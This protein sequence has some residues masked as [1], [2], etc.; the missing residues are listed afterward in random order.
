MRG[1]LGLNLITLKGAPGDGSLEER[2]QAAAKAGFEGVGLWM[3]DL[4]WWEKEKGNLKRL[5][6]LIDSLGLSVAEICAVTVCDDE[7]KVASRLKEFDQAATVGAHCMICIY[8][9]REARVKTAR[10]QWAEFLD[11]LADF[12][13]R[14]AFEFIGSTS[15]YN[16]LDTALDVV[17]GGPPTGGIVVDTYHFWRGHSNINTL[18][19]LTP[20][21]LVLVHLNDVK[22]VDREK[23]TDR[24]RT[25][26]GE[27]IM[28]L[29]H[30]LTSIASTGYEGMYDVEIFGECQEQDRE[31]V[32]KTSADTARK[33]LMKA[34][35]R[36]G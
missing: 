28:P 1:Q 24:D 35:T 8:N 26:P 30:I 13:V 23:A 6:R 25:Y 19:H 33:A 32:A 22:R 29:T 14:A 12:G 3:K 17:T 20:N 15:A 16:T 36:Q 2:L 11:P 10:E 7:K 5:R 4:E 21:Q 9:N 18:S 34:A 27:G 31:K